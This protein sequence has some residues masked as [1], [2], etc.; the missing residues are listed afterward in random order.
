V[1]IARRLAVVLVVIAGMAAIWVFCIQPYECNRIKRRATAITE[2]VYQRDGTLEAKVMA[3]RNLAVM[4]PCMRVTCRDVSLDMIAAANLRALGRNEDAAV[5]YRHALT[6]DR[7]P[8]IYLNL[9]SSELALGDRNAARDDMLRA[10]MFNP[11]LIGQID[12]GLLRQEVVKRMIE[13]RPENA[14]F[15]HYVDALPLAP[16]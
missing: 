5:M 2:A 7:R 9:A 12:D 14:E 16:Q 4:D 6:L 8:E 10:T 3:R 11:W 15:I 13:L 1:R